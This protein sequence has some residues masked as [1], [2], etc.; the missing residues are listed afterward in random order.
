MLAERYVRGITPGYL[1]LPGG[2][3]VHY[4]EAGYPDAQPVLLTHGFLGSSNDWRY[5]I[6][7]LAYGSTK[8][9][10]VIAPDWPGF[11]LTD[12]PAK[13]P[14]SVTYYSLFIK[15]FA[16]A[17][18]L[19][20]FDLVGHSMGGR[21]SAA[22][23]ILNPEYVRRL[24][25]VAPANFENDAMMLKLTNL[26][27]SGLL[28]DKVVKALGN[29]VNVKKHLNIIFHNERYY[30]TN[31]EIRELAQAFSQPEQVVALKA[32]TKAFSHLG[33]ELDH[34]KSRL[35][36]IK[37]PTLVIAGKQDRVFSPEVV[38][39]IKN[40]VAHT[41]FYWLDNCGHMPQIEKSYEVNRM[42]AAFLAAEKL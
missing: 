36:E 16:D 1:T 7:K 5:N 4:L 35:G 8:N 32:M 41:R 26:P 38:S 31:S 14:Y 12:K 2:L 10:R 23:T 19:K 39:K 42:M 40:F 29:P 25:L 33:N 9:F 17:L 30:P 27:F 34:F 6:E 13:A 28:L 11:G 3:K 15:A 24:I 21:Y 18:D 22:F 20:K 37:Q